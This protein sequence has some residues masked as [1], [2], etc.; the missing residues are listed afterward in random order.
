[1]VLGLCAT[2]L[3][4]E[5]G[6]FTFS[7]AV[8]A[9]CHEDITL[10][11]LQ[12]A[13][14]PGGRSPAP[15]GPDQIGRALVDVP[16]RLRAPLR[17][18]WSLA[19][20]F[21]V[22][23]NDLRGFAADNLPGLASVHNDPNDQRAHCL[24]APGDD[25]P[26]GDAR[27]LAACRAFILEE[28]AAA[29]GPSADID[30]SADEPVRVALTFRGTVHLPLQSYAF[31]MGKALHALQDS[32]THCLRAPGTGR[33]R[34]VFNFIDWALEPGYSPDRDGHRHLSPLDDCEAPTDGARRRVEGAT[35]ASA[36][37]LRA[38][39]EPAG[40]RSGR[41]A[42]A[43]AVLDRVLAREPGCT[44]ANRYCDAPELDEAAAAEGCHTRPG[45]A[46]RAGAM[47]ALLG[48]A[49]A[50][51]GRLRRRGGALGAALA[52]GAALLAG[53]AEGRAQTRTVVDRTDELPPSRWG[54]QAALGA[55]MDRGAF[56]YR[57]GFHVNLGARWQVALLAE[58]NPWYSL[59][60][61]RFARGTFNV[62]LA[63]TF[64]W[65]RFGR[66][67]IQTTVYAGVSALLVD[68]VAADAGAVGP[69]VGVN[70]LGL[71]VPLGR[72]LTLLVQPT[73]FMVPVPQLRGVP[74]Y[75][76]QYRFEVGVA[77]H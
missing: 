61:G 27:A 35:E 11:A 8:S 16:F 50:A 64:A 30:L 37:L 4:H 68:L 77:W 12:Q 65:Q 7:S 24:R 60:V 66:L 33:V 53:P 42:R 26:D 45:G 54:L 29:L 70:L 48:F 25:G 69:M 10:D 36:A 17:D 39:S 34:H 49:V 63:G 14:W 41:L 1:M 28:V 57:A 23:D 47:T 19:L 22:R 46:K 5:A 71:R 55:S 59:S 43:G 31:H 72:T 9:G 15:L 74:F 32:Y 52:V 21:G 56:A 6:A 38:V 76:H 13:G 51:A 2:A 73:T 75:Y 20:V 58:H 62:M 44:A 67:T 3:S 40:G 18:P